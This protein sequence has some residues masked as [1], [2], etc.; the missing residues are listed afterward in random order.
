MWTT[1]FVC[2]V[3]SKH[4]FPLYSTIELNYNVYRLCSNNIHIKTQAGAE[5]LKTCGRLLKMG[6]VGHVL[7]G[8]AAKFHCT[9]LRKALNPFAPNVLG[10]SGTELFGQPQ[11][12]VSNLMSLSCKYSLLA[13]YPS[14]LLC[15]SL[16]LSAFNPTVQWDVYFMTYNLQFTWLLHYVDSVI[17]SQSQPQ[18]EPMQIPSGFHILSMSV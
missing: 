13:L 18:S 16:F 17:W 10:I 5:Q 15:L 1:H 6:T 12:N 8:N 9:A 7:P 2:Y 14:L 3:N 4:W 11:K